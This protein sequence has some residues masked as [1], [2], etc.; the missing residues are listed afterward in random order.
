MLVTFL[1]L[2]F[3]TTFTHSRFTVGII[4]RT[5]FQ[6]ID[7]FIF[8]YLSLFTYKYSQTQFSAVDFFRWYPKTRGHPPA[9]ADGGNGQD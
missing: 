9:S 3:S 5:D 4:Q 8:S 6:L 7:Y 2:H 1:Y